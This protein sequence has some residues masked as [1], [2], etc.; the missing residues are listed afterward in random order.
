MI[1]GPDGNGGKYC[2]PQFLLNRFSRLVMSAVSSTLAL[3]PVG[4]FTAYR[5]SSWFAHGARAVLRSAI[6]PRW[7]LVEGSLLRNASSCSQVQLITL[8]CSA[9]AGPKIMP[10]LKMLSRF[11]SVLK[12]I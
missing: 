6:S 12:T 3:L 11:A 9:V 7:F 8:T 1:E 2:Q 4:T 10:L 5:K